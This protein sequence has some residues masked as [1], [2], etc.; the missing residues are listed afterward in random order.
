ME[1]KEKVEEVKEE[2]KEEKEVKE[3]PKG[4]YLTQ[5]PASYQQVIALGDKQVQ[6]EELI[7]KMANAIKAAGLFKD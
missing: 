2:V 5:I 3:I 1:E 7:I 6:T 4:Y